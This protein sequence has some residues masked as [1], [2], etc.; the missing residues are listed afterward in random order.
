MTTHTIKKGFD[1]RLA[2]RAEL[3]LV[4]A[5]EAR[6][7][8]IDAAD[9]PGLKLK[10]LVKEGD[11][12]KTG[13]P[14]MLD[15]VDRNVVWA[16][17]ATGK[18]L[19]VDYGERRALLRIVIEGAGKD[20][21]HPTPAWKTGQSREEVVQGLQQAGLWPLLRQRPIGRIAASD[22]EPAAIFV[23]GMGSEPL[24]ADQAFA[25]KGRK[26]ELQA[27]IEVLQRL[28][29]GKVYLCLKAAGDHQSDLRDLRGVEVHDFSG[30]HPAGLVGTHISRIRP[31]R[32]NEV[33]WYL[34]AQEA[35]LLGEW[36]RTGQYPWRR[37]VAVAGTC[38][39]QKQYF[40]VRQGAAI[41]NLCGGKAPA[42]DVRVING[43]VLNGTAMDPGGS[44]GFYAHTVTMIPEGEGRRDLFGWAL[45]QFGKFSFHRSVFGWLVPRREYDLDARY[46]GGER[47]IVNIGAWESVMALDIHPS[48]VVRAIQANDLE[49]AI[50]LGLLEVTEEDVAL[51][52]FVDPCKIDVGA[53][54]RKGLDL[55]EKEG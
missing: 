13:Q 7:V 47:P 1:I 23:N 39:P 44:L 15:K 20:E 32:G 16:S 33:A 22:R 5:P 31:L 36:A 42:G 24:A 50:K 43:T 10:A 11:R 38:A 19:R 12:V 8:T 18:V 2:G 21:F 26:A 27:G 6:V 35:V 28:T 52:T 4:D 49:E 55:Y 9:F 40:R 29:S 53:T 41:A 37:I 3:R 45:P 17:P 48:F 30:P 25:T 54:I 34:T 46:N 51:C 14:V